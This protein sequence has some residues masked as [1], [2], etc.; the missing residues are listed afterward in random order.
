AAEAWARGEFVDPA[1]QNQ[2]AIAHLFGESAA[3]FGDVLVKFAAR[4][5]DE[6]NGGGRRGGAYIG[7]KIGDGEISFVADPGDHGDF[8]S[9]DSAGDDFFV[10]SPQIFH[11]AAAAREDEHVNEFRFIEKLQRLDDFFGG[12]FALHAH[13]IEHQMDIGKAARANPSHRAEHRAR[14]L[15]DYSDAAGKKRQRFSARGIEKSFG[16]EAF[17]QLLEGKLQCALPHQVNFLDVNLIFAALFVDADGT[18]HGNLQT[19]FGAE[20]DAA[21]LLL[22]INATDLGAVVLQGEIDVAGLGCAAVGDF[23]LHADVG[24]ILGEQVA[25][26]SDQFADGEDLASGHEVESELLVHEEGP[27]KDEA[28]R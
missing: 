28:M 19:V 26:F 24:E 17:F 1:A 16:F 12:A 11:G 27:R 22:E 20:L 5:H 7:D 2:D 3:Q 9:E 15:T 10:E 18:A 6:L 13:G 21:L 14:W 25:N 8:G 4:L 23:A